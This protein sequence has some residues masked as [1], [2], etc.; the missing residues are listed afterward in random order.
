MSEL[1]E[2]TKETNY[3]TSGDLNE[4]YCFFLWVAACECDG[5]RTGGCGACT[6]CLAKERKTEFFEKTNGGDFF[7]NEREALLA[8]N[9]ELEAERDRL[10]EAAKKAVYRVPSWYPEIRKNLE[11]AISHVKQPHA[12][13]T[14][15]N[16]NEDKAREIAL[17][18]SL[19]LE[20]MCDIRD[21]LIQAK[22]GDYPVS[23]MNQAC[24]YC[25]VTDHPSHIC[26]GMELRKALEQERARAK[27]MVHAIKYVLFCGETSVIRKSGLCKRC[28]EMLKGSLAA[29]EGSQE[30]EG[31]GKI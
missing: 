9:K 23:G 26:N 21:A 8:E 31:N 6:P 28:E 10:L 30:K 14:T 19:G 18:Y 16:E 13:E 22:G 2:P 7:V 12:K 4:L 5:S 3:L 25:G 20:A 15:M 29:Y 27:D 11:K 17:K 1:N 24:R